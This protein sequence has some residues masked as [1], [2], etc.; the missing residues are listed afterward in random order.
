MMP[1]MTE[2]AKLYR[3]VQEFHRTP[4]PYCGEP[5]MGD[6]PPTRDHITPRWRGGSDLL[7]V[8][9]VCNRDK[10]GKTLQQWSHKLVRNRDWRAQ[11]V[12][13]LVRELRLSSRRQG[14][15]DAPASSQPPKWP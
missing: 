3:T 4:C 7:V 1:A 5:M 15:S 12:G 2:F 13:A 9:L 11:R 10:G 14:I 6:R 8:C